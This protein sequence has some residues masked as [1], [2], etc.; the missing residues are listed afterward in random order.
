MLCPYCNS[1]GCEE[2]C[3]DFC[4]NCNEPVAKD[5]DYCSDKC[6]KEYELNE[7]NE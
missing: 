3:V 7:Y 1:A 4:I 6:Q 5:N 2:D